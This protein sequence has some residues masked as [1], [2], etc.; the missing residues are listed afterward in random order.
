MA[1]VTNNQ[2]DQDNP[3]YCANPDCDCTVEPGEKYCSAECEKQLKSGP[4]SCGHSNC[5]HEHE[6]I[7]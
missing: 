5:Q 2:T 7:S 6:D 1:T 4:C 3:T